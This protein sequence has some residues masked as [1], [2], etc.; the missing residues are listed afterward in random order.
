M[1]QQQRR[2]DRKYDS[3]ARHQDTQFPQ[4]SCSSLSKKPSAFNVDRQPLMLTLLIPFPGGFFHR[5][6]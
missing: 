5:A 2:E 3:Q 6:S 1:G 4:N